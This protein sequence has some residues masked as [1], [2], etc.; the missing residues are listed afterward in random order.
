VEDNGESGL[1]H[2]Q[3]R[4]AGGLWSD[5]NSTSTVLNISML[6][7]GRHSLEVRAID[8]AGNPSSADAMWIRIDRTAPTLDIEQLSAQYAGPPVLEID[9]QVSDGDGSGISSVEWSWNNQTWQVMPAG[10]TIIWSN[11]S[12]IDLY[13]KATD[14]VGMVVIENLTI[15]P[16]ANPN[17]PT[18]DNSGSDVESSGGPST[19]GVATIILIAL[20]VAAMLGGGLYLIFRGNSAGEDD[21]ED[22]E[23]QQIEPE[24]ESLVIQ[25][26]ALATQVTHVNSHE[27]LPEGGT[28]DSTTGTTWYMLPDGNKWWMQEDGSFVLYQSVEAITPENHVVSE[29]NGMQ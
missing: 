22:D 29:E 13:V 21:E 18:D 5:V 24:G 26:P 19:M 27:W 6:N 16:P 11:W 20:V 15:D 8:N 14:N 23:E 2:Y 28:Y 4:W 3:I 7:D 10:N 9:V 1:S 25:E 12:E 17:Q